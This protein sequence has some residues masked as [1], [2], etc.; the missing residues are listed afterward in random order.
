MRHV[1][2]ILVAASLL[3]GC[4][5]P[6]SG[7]SLGTKSSQ[8]LGAKDTFIDKDTDIDRIA[9]ELLGWSAKPEYGAPYLLF[10]PKTELHITNAASASIPTNGDEQISPYMVVHLI[11][12]GKMEI[13]DED[14]ENPGSTEYPGDFWL[15][16]ANNAPETGDFDVLVKQ[17]DHYAANAN[18]SWDNLNKVLKIDNRL[19]ET[20][21][22]RAADDGCEALV[23]M[24]DYYC[25]L[26]TPPNDGK[27]LGYHRSQ[28]FIIT[29]HMLNVAKEQKDF[30]LLHGL[31]DWFSKDCPGEM[32]T[33][34]KERQDKI[35]EVDA[36]INSLLGIDA[37]RLQQLK[38]TKR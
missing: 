14:P 37:A 26:K 38:G 35:N 1:V 23:T 21:A 22:A 27:G 28:V 9:R 2:A 3:V 13:V 11:A 32:F 8:K 17:R 7:P 24:R 16:L 10:F 25:N 6:Q 34:S 18:G 20:A 15:T 12:A 31:R 30:D 29:T 36:V 5:L 19:I 4:G 33:N